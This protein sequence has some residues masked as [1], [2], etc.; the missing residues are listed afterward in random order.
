[1]EPW[2]TPA[3]L[4]AVV[5]GLFTYMGTKSQTRMQKDDK[6]FDIMEKRLAKLEEKVDKLQA[7]LDVKNELL[8][9]K[10][11]VIIQQQ[12]EIDDLKEENGYLIKKIEKKEGTE[13][14]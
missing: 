2:I 13:N 7:D 8:A 12:H 5:T 11:R 3:V 10:E 4:V 6:A 1:M 9:E 14:G